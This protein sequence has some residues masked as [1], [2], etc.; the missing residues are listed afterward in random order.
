MQFIPLST[1]LIET[2][3]PSLLASV[4]IISRLFMSEIIE[5]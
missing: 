2:I 5:I 3:F 1:S 4:I